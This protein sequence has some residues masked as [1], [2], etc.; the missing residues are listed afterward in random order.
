MNQVKEQEPRD[1]IEVVQCET[2]WFAR[3]QSQ[4]LAAI[5]TS[6]EDAYARLRGVLDIVS[7]LTEKRMRQTQL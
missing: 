2:G 3:S 4:R 6:Q 1:D 7:K 5:G